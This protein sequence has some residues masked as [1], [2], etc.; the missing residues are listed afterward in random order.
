[1]V[2]T[3]AFGTVP[4]LGD[5]EGVAIAAGLLILT[6]STG[7]L[8]QARLPMPGGGAL[9]YSVI[10]T[11]IGRRC[12]VEGLAYDQSGRVLLLACK[13]GLAGGGRDPLVFRWSLDGKALA[14]PDRVALP[15]G[16]LAR[17]RKATGFH[18]SAIEI[19]PRTGQ[20]VILASVDGAVA[21]V[22]R[23]GKVLAVGRLQ[24]HRQPEGLA[25]GRD[26]RVYVADEGRKGPG[27]VTGYDCR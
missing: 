11:G 4:P 6:T 5:F 1:M 2:A 26:G 16:A 21:S 8:Y 23:T 24:R 7:D 15:A 18:P 22:D 9:E 25:I 20:W 12:E 3:H 27:S 14:E 19:D 17:S 13:Q 10:R